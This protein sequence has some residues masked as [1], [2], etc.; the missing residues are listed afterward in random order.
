MAE[1]F[2][3]TSALVLTGNTRT[4]NINDHVSEADYV[5]NSIRDLPQLILNVNKYKS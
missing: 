3:F 5:I 4:N 2:Q 1:E